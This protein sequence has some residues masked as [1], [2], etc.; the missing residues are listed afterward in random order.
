MLVYYNWLRHLFIDMSLFKKSAKFLSVVGGQE[1]KS[2]GM[3]LKGRMKDFY[4]RSVNP[5]APMNRAGA[6]LCNAIEWLSGG[7]Q[8]AVASASPNTGQ[9]DQA[10]QIPDYLGEHNFPKLNDRQRALVNEALH[11]RGHIKELARLLRKHN[12]LQELKDIEN[13]AL[14]KPK[15]AADKL[16]NWYGTLSW[17][18]PDSEFYDEKHEKVR[19]RW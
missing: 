7:V 12:H 11:E 8:T 17:Q 3:G 1:P 5:E 15:A 13:L 16:V 9:T 14:A 19:V 10:N 2:P 6:H 18:A 4:G